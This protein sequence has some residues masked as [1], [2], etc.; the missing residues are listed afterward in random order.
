MNVV[1]K[2]R[3]GMM[4]EEEEEE[5]EEEEQTKLQFKNALLNRESETTRR[6]DPWTTSKV[7]FLFCSKRT[8]SL[9]G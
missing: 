2:G 3:R 8:H 4:G 5:E 1:Q 6:V 9:V 7:L